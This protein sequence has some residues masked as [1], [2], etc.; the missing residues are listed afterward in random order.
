METAYGIGIMTFDHLVA[1]NTLFMA[2]LATF[3]AHDNDNNA[4]AG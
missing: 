1:H 2:Y 3:F 4:S